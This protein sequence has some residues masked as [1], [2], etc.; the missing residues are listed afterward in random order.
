MVWPIIWITGATIIFH[1]FVIDGYTTGMI[2]PYSSYPSPKS[3][4]WTCVSRNCVM[5]C[6]S[7]K[8]RLF[9]NISLFKI[10]SISFTS[11]VYYCLGLALKD[12]SILFPRSDN[13][14]KQ[15]FSEK[16]WFLTFFIIKHSIC[17][18][19]ALF[20]LVLPDS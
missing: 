3:R 6:L 14:W 20:R 12:L 11:S 2:C 16:S 7:E 13:L 10:I 4:Y 9:S 17:L 18:D 8:K 1:D 15:L 19:C 5:Q